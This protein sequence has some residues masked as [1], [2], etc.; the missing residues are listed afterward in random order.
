MLHGVCMASRGNIHAAVLPAELSSR[1]AHLPVLPTG[2][3]EEAAAALLRVA[4]WWVCIWLPLQ[5]E[6]LRRHFE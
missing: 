3:S 6:A 1:G 5:L 4:S 2:Q